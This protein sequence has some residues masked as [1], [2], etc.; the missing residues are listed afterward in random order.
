MLVLNAVATTAVDNAMA[1]AAMLVDPAST[2]A[3]VRV[4]RF[5]ACVTAG[6]VT[7]VAIVTVHCVRGLRVALAVVS[8]S[9]A[10]AVPE[11][12]AETVNVVDPHPLAAGVA[13]DPPYTKFGNTSVIVSL[14]LISAFDAKMNEM[15]VAVEVTGLN[16]VKVL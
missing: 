8:V 15:A 4:L 9:A 2:S 1:L 5:A 14:T 6:V 13:I 7:P 16:K 10:E 11:F 12:A 3:A